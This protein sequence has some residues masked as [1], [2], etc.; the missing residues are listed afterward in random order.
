M[1]FAAKALLATLL[2][3]VSLVG[4]SRAAAIELE[5]LPPTIPAQPVCV[6][7]R[8]D[9]VILQEWRAW[10]RKTLPQRAPSLVLDDA[11]RLRD[12][13][14]IRNFKIVDAVLHLLPSIDP[15]RNRQ[16][17]DVE[18]ISLYLA[19]GR[20]RELKEMGIVDQLAASDKPLSPKALNTL[21]EIY[22]SGALGIKDDKRANSYL[23]SAAYGGNADALLRLAKMNLDGQTVE[24][25]TVEPDLAVLMAFGAL[26]GKLDDSIC[27]RI[28]RIAREYE[29]GGVV[30]R[31]DQISEQWY[32][33]AADL[34]DIN[35]AWKVAK[36]HLESEQIDKQN[37]VLLKYLQ[38]ASDG[39]VVTARIELGRLYEDGALVPADLERAAAYYAGA[40]AE[41]RGGL[42]RLVLMYERQERNSDQQKRYVAALTRLENLQNAPGWAYSK[43]AKVVIAE[44]GQWAGEDQAR[45]LLEKGVALGDADSTQILASLLLRRRDDPVSF[46]R[47]LDLL[48]RAVEADG[49][50]DPMTELR[51]AHLCRAPGG[52][53]L[54]LARYWDAIETGAANSSLVMQPEDIEMLS[55]GADPLTIATL[56]T[57]AL[58]G[59]QKSVAYYLAYLERTGASESEV[60]F[61]KVRARK[62]PT[63]QAAIARLDYETSPSPGE[64]ERILQTFQDLA[65]ELPEVGI[66]IGQ[67]T[68]DRFPQDAERVQE[69]ETYLRRA[70]QAGF[71]KALWMLADMGVHGTSKAEIYS[72]F[73]SVIEARGDAQA[74]M[75]AAA[76]VTD[77]ERK[78]ALLDRAIGVTP[79]DFETSLQLAG[80]HADLGDSA[81]VANW[82]DVSEEL[83]KD[84]AWRYVA[85]A[86]GRLKLQGDTQTP[87]AAELYALAL[88]M[89]EDSAVRRLLKI[90]SDAESPLY[91]PSKAAEMLKTLLHSAE[92]ED[93]EGLL[94][95]VRRS[96][97]EIRDLV[98]VNLSV[99]ELYRKPAEA[100]NPVAMRELAELIRVEKS[101]QETAIEAATWFK[102]AADLGDA[103]AMV[104]LAKAYALGL[105]V[106]PSLSSATSWL[107]L[108]AA[109]GNPEAKTLLATM[110]P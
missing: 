22:L 35:A 31:S 26:V 12:L 42:I 13:D 66:D 59:R 104:E 73:A 97:P 107:K 2:V 41:S 67:I 77:P 74:L 49:R 89:G 5:F 70:V 61:W 4:E 91:Q 108:A 110:T 65:D 38:M 8:P 32:R 62:N 109:G 48:T 25:W 101:T 99:I 79:C 106:K 33:M 40:G 92:A 27:D 85:V 28:G 19:A 78:A 14:P 23:V 71:G 50:I 20:V 29:Q 87:R 9:E 11:R 47:G 81:Q 36:L 18:R 69:A 37:D 68:M 88:E 64:V 98:L 105:G 7:K 84:T 16:E 95:R 46:Q 45:S 103:E 34:G 55:A 76:A 44:Q 100:G 94:K 21:A 17:I 53:N 80:A 93:I 1:G 3:S 30:R 72:E 54:E 86:D 102:K 75:F 43:L 10:D 56:Q 15:K 60:A 58:Y 39:G 57:Q 90:Y 83:A 63:I 24:N 82:L 52:A 96:P 6:M 51:D